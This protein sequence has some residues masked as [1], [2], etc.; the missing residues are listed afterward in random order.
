MNTTISFGSTAIYPRQ[1]SVLGD[2]VEDDGRTWYRITDIDS[3][4]PF[5]VSVTNP[6][7]I[8]IFISTTGGIT[9]GR[10]SRESAL[11]PYVTGDKIDDACTHTGSLTAFHITTDT[12]TYL[13]RPLDRDDPR[14]YDTT[15]SFHKSVLGDAVIFE[16]RNTTLGLE[17][18]S[19][20]QASPRF[21]IHRYTRLRNIS[22][23]VIAVRLLDGI[24]N[25]VPSGVTSRMQSL[26]SN[27]LDAYKRSEYDPV[28]RLGIFALSATPT[29]LA[30]PSESLRATTV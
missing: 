29:D 1:R 27:L 14:V 15:R 6:A 23:S 4:P 25:I 21:G 24:R 12:G 20:W 8:W 16:E 30:E 26:F 10:V 3:L 19:A 2:F 5:L 13:W 11:F 28:S 9:A 22:G 17:F 18:R 7:D